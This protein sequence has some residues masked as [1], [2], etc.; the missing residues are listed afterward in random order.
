MYVLYNVHLDEYRM[1]SVLCM[2]RLFA[3]D[4]QNLAFRWYS[5]NKAMSNA[6]E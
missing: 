5:W 2:H 1:Y 4:R 6:V 3:R